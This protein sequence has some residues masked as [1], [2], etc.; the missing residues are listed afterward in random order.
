MPAAALC[1]GRLDCDDGTDETGCDCPPASLRCADGLCVAA[2][3][4]CDTVADCADGSDELD[5]PAPPATA[6]AAAPAPPALA[7]ATL[8]DPL[9]ELPA[10]GCGPTQFTCRGVGDAGGGAE[11]IPLSWRCDGRAD[12]TDGSDETLHCGMY[13]CRPETHPAMWSVTLSC[14]C[15]FLWQAAHTGT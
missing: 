2:A 14:T 1:D 12:C 7:P 5:C 10:L 6:P 4:R 11:C 8:P 9:G 13:P 15:A 3:A